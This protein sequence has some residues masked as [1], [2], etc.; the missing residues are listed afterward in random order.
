[1][2]DMKK[3][4]LKQLD[5]EAKIYNASVAAFPGID[6]YCS[7]TDWIIPYWQSFTP[8]NRL[9]IYRRNE[10]FVALSEHSTPEGDVIMSPLEAMWGFPS[11]L[12]G[13]ESADMLAELLS[14]KNRR[15]D[16]R[17]SA[18]ILSG[19]PYDTGLLGALVSAVSGCCRAYM[20]E[21]THRCVASLDGGIDGFL[22]RR[23]VKF[24]V[25]LRKAL[26]LTSEEG[27]SFRRIARLRGERLC[28]MYD[29]I[30]D[31][32]RRSWKGKSG[33]GADQMPMNEF[34]RLM[35]RRIAPSGRLR[36]ITAEQNGTAVGYIYGA[37]VGG[38]YRGLQ[39]S[40][41]E[42]LA[43]VSLGN[44]LQYRMIEWLCE[45][46]CSRYDLGSLVP[47]KKK[48]AEGDCKTMTVWLKK[49]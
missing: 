35:L 28:S 3:L 14:A 37:V 27:I 33:Q 13:P 23:A 26:R 11:A 6:P 39:F 12:V 18:V 20:L 41:D 24:R 21:P 46:G 30:L 4:S 44:V 7:R 48:W 43:P 31:I 1:M 2:Q 10:S 32:E 42:R 38:R 16:C 19:F 5:R 17:C 15:D 34:Y 29:S 8:E 40:F 49:Y 9:C 45:E 25:N 36:L 22:G 47:Y